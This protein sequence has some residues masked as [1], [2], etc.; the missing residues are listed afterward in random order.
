MPSKKTW[1]G[2]EFNR[3]VVDEV[4]DRRENCEGNP[5][6]GSKGLDCDSPLGAWTAQPWYALPPPPFYNSHVGFEIPEESL[7]PGGLA[8]GKGT[9]WR[10]FASS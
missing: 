7:C 2:V 10:V 6:K 4:H 8:D 1:D 9:A 3:W 5:E